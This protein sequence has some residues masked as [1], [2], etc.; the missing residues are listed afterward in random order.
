MGSQLMFKIKKNG[1]I[2][3]LTIVILIMW[4]AVINKINNSNR[5]THQEIKASQEI[6]Y[7]KK[8]NER[9]KRFQSIFYY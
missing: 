6:M 2:S 4:I 8:W 7:W 5:N 9:K 1:I 3:S